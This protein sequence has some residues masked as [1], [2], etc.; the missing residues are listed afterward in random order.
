MNFRTA[1]LA[2]ALA[3]VFG[4]TALPAHAQPSPIPVALAKQVADLQA[5]VAKLEGTIV[6]SDL[7]GTYAVHT[8][9][10]HLSSAAPAS[11]AAVVSSSTVTLNA[12]G[13]GVLSP[14]GSCGGAV[15]MPAIGVLSPINCTGAPGYPFT[16]T[17]ADGVLD[18]ILDPLYVPG[19]GTVRFDVG[20]GG[21][22]MTTSFA[23]AYGTDADT[24]FLILTRL[25]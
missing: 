15:L 3:L 2:S 6:A 11:I 9:D 14:A 1:A 7:A 13:T 18:E 20:I 8:I 12:D 21:R 23:P 25:K 10:T 5:R 16:W 22:I 4:F 24:L 17:Y 19:G